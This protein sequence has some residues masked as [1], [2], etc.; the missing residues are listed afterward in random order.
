MKT[1]S[2]TRVDTMMK[3]APQLDP[4]NYVQKSYCSKD[5]NIP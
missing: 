2:K 5:E 3:I 4:R 1:F